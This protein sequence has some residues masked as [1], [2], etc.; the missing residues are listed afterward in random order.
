MDFVPDMEWD[1]LVAIARRASGVF[2]DADP[3]LLMAF[4]GEQFFSQDPYLPLDVTEVLASIQKTSDPPRVPRTLRYKT[5]L[6]LVAVM[7]GCR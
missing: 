5:I 4:A 2:P 6:A 1:R 3:I 7:K